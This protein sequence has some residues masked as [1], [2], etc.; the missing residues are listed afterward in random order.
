MALLACAC[1]GGED[2]KR[3]QPV[4][5][6]GT[7]GT[8]S[9]GSGGGSAGSS[10]D[11]GS[12][13]EAGSPSEGGA[14]GEPVAACF[15]PGEDCTGDENGCC[16]DATCVHDTSSPM[17]GV[18][19]A[20]CTDGADCVSGCCTELV[21]QPGAV[22][23]PAEYCADECFEA[24]ESCGADFEGCCADSV[25][26]SAADGTNCAALCDQHTDCNSGC[27]AP[28]SNSDNYVCSPPEFCL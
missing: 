15:E 3:E 27:C 9:A 19:A 26:V 20:I 16:D 12:A 22:C 25:C 23:A 8:A 24:G 6:A 14:G 17:A 11:A 5:T 13:G 21:D 18:C 2:E 7:G 28:L 10:S 1:G 4:G